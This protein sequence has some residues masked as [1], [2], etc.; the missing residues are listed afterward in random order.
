MAKQN[1]IQTENDIKFET[2]AQENLEHRK[3]TTRAVFTK[4][5][6]RKELADGYALRYPKTGEW[7][8]R[9]QDFSTI[10]RRSCPYMNFEVIPEANNGATWLHITGPEGTKNFVESSQQM[11]T[12]YL[13]PGTNSSPGFK[14]KFAALT[15][16]WRV[17]P[18]FLIIGAKKC[19]TT[20]LYSY[21]TQH[22]AVAPASMKEIYYFVGNYRCGLDWYRTFFPT[23][24]ERFF[25]KNVVQRDFMTGEATPEYIVHPRA[26]KRVRATLPNVKLI[27]ILRNPVDKAYSFYQHQLRNGVETLPFEE[28]IAREQEILKNNPGYFD[29]NYS[30]LLPGMYASQIKNWLRLFPKEQ[31]LILTNEALNDTPDR[32]VAEAIAFLGLPKYEQIK[33]RKLNAFPYPDMDGAVRSRL[34]DYFAPHNRKLYKMLGRDLGW[35]K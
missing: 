35:E 28:A 25:A 19:G 17:L 20:S 6:E 3:E 8:A 7:T 10:W 11:L 26:P 23:V 12:S 18:D 21:V 9:L 31:L 33:F 27:A 22:P 24:F 2:R 34:L 29:H 14:Q 1:N 15:R 16:K 4:F 30:Y 5:E 13:N 32:T